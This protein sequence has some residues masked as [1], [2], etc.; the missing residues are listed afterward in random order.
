[1]SRV[2]IEQGSELDCLESYIYSVMER[3]VFSF[4]LPFDYQT[5][6]VVYNIFL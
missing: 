4:N 6:D 1:M 5:Q 3:K 2:Y